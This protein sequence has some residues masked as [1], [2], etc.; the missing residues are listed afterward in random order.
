MEK[1]AAKFAA[2]YK[3]CFLPHADLYG[4]QT[5]MSTQSLQK[6]LSWDT[7]CSDIETM[8]NSGKLVDR[9]RLDAMYTYMYGF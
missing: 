7:F 5:S 1:Q 8:E 9:L 4:D 2:F 3:I 6:Y